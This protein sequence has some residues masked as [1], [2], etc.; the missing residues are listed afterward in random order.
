MSGKVCFVC[1]SASFFFC[2]NSGIWLTES[3]EVN[4]DLVDVVFVV[5]AFT[6]EIAV[7]L[8]YYYGYFEHGE[9][10]TV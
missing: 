9:R 7:L 4:D 2:P 5:R 6:A 10:L 3:R 1:N 8:V